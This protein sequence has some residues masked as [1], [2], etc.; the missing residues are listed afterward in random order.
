MNKQKVTLIFLLGFVFSLGL[1][2][3][4]YINSTFLS[5]YISEK[6][7]GLF[8]IISST[9]TIILM[10]GARKILVKI[11]NYKTAFWAIIINILALAGLSFFNNFII[12]AISLTLYL[13]VTTI[14]SF[15]LDVF[16]E[17]Y[18]KNSSTGSTRGTYLSLSNLAWLISPAISGFILYNNEYWKIYLV[19]GLLMIPILYLLTKNFKNFKDPVYKKNDFLKTLKIILKRKNLAK[20]FWAQFLLS[21]FYAWM[22]IY[23]PIYLH[24]HIGFDWKTIGIMFTIMLL[25]FFLL[26]MPLGKLADKKFGEKEILNLGF[27]ITGVSTASLAFMT[28]N[29]VVLWAVLLFITRIGASMIEVSSETYF[30]KKIDGD[31]ANIL[32]LFRVLRPLAYV[33]SP[34]I[35]SILLIFIGMN[36]LFIVLGIIVM[37][38]GI[39]IEMNLKDTK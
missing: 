7:V 4:A 30:F 10:V 16:L 21:F 8:Y 20:I 5:T 11:G 3:P 17:S 32:N 9:L 22:V 37:V 25:P 18:S 29:N 14:I 24:D 39:S 35:A 31:N 26:E 34:I 28:S 27:L 6:T 12:I 2:I 19:S 1:A 38:G 33:L 23:M 15:N 36:Y 13:I